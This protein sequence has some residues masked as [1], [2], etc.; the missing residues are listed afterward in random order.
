MLRMSEETIADKLEGDVLEQIERGENAE[1]PIK[2]IKKRIDTN[3]TQR[4]FSISRIPTD[5]H[6]DFKTLA[7]N[8]FADDYGM[9]LAFLIRYFK[10]TDGNNRALES[11]SKDLH[12]RLDDIE[13]QLQGESD[14]GKVST[15]Q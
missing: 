6:Q 13:E 15:I 3:D 9:A 8:M 14:G 12:D 10:M 4:G 5:A 7:E 1:N 11:V 2:R